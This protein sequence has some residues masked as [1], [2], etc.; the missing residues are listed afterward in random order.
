MC[1]TLLGWPV[2]VLMATRPTS[3][4]TL[5]VA[6]QI[7]AEAHRQ[8]AEGDAATYIALQLADE[9]RERGGWKANTCQPLLLAYISARGEDEEPAGP[10]LLLAEIFD[11]A[12]PTGQA[13]AARANPDSH[14]WLGHDR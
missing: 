13:E 7:L 1:S 10:E 5:S 3:A 14:E 9:L 12:S 4:L 11:P 8:A 2:G 6:H